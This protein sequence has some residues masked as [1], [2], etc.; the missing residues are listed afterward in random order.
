MS[1]ILTPASAPDGYQVI[2]VTTGET[3]DAGEDEI[4]T[5]PLAAHILSGLPAT[6][7]YVITA[8]TAAAVAREADSGR[9]IYR[10][11]GFGFSPETI[12]DNQASSGC[13][14]SDALEAGAAA[15]I[16]YDAGDHGDTSAQS[17]IDDFQAAVS[18]AS[19]ELR[20]ISSLDLSADTL[21]AT[22]L[23]TL[24]AVQARIREG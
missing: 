4:L 16:F 22:D 21:S 6:G 9:G 11:E 8:V 17:V 12:P 20:C 1:N 3:V 19:R 24:R 5:W 2:D 15:D 23:E 14:L 10:S 18:A 13:A 7:Q